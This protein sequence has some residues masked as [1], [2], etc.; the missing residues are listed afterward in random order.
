MKAKTSKRYSAE[1]KRDALDLLQTTPKGI[2]QVARE[3]GISTNTLR[4]WR[5]SALGSTPTNPKSK[6]VESLSAQELFEQNQQ[7]QKENEYL[8]R[9]RE[10]LKKAASILAEDPQLGMR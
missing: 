8:R 5:N 10:I 1:F 3:L 2:T 6:D 7:L 9:Q 4:Y